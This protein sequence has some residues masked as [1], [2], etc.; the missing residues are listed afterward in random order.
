MFYIES[1]RLRMIPLTHELLQL[2]HASRQTMELALG[3]NISNPQISDFYKKE[4]DDALV[5]FWLPKTLANP[6]AYKWY[7]DWEIILKN[8]NISIGG[9]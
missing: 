7:T 2:L 9:L 6:E 8:T 5:N 1:E 3:L 4:I